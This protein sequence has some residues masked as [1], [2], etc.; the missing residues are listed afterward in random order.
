MKTA[1]EIPPDIRITDFAREL[2]NR[3]LKAAATDKS[4][5]PIKW[6]SIK[7]ELR[8]WGLWP[9]DSIK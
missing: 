8:D 9:I 3:M 6:R 4:I 2:E 7:N 1:G 5:R